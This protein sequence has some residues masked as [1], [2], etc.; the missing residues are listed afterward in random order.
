MFFDLETG[1]EYK[2]HQRGFFDIY[3]CIAPTIILVVAVFT[4]YNVYNS[5]TNGLYFHLA[6]CCIFFVLVL[7][8]AF[9]CM[10]TAKQCIKNSSC[11]LCRVARRFQLTWAGRNTEDILVVAGVLMQ[12]FILYG[13]VFNGQCDSTDLWNSQVSYCFL[14]YQRTRL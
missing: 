12:G 6:L 13:R 7:Y 10:N 14:D 2:V 11:F 8:S 4:R 1:A 3:E 5:T 9:I